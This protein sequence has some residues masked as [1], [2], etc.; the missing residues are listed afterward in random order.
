MLEVWNMAHDPLSIH[1][2]QGICPCFIFSLFTLQ[3]ESQFKTGLIELNTKESD[4][5]KKLESGQIQDLV[6]QSQISTGWK[7][8]WANYSIHVT[9][10]FYVSLRKCLQILHVA[11]KSAN[12][13]FSRVRWPDVACRWFEIW[14]RLFEGFYHI[15]TTACVWMYTCYMCIKTQYSYDKV[16]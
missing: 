12:S 8:E 3:H 2:I 7:L 11:I 15:K 1:C 6:N 13:V 5:V 16:I 14:Q 9:K 10:N 4:F